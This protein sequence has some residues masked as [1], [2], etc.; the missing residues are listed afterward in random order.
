MKTPI[1]LIAI[2]FSARIFAQDQAATTIEAKLF[3]PAHIKSTLTAADKLTVYFNPL[4]DDSL[5]KKMPKKVVAKKTKDNMYEFQLPSTRFWQIGFSIGN[6][7]YQMMCVDNRRGD[8]NEVY[9][10][11]I[12]LENR[13]FVK[14]TKLP[15]CINTDDDN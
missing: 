3:L 7:S 5:S 2:L 11:D 6:Y 10:F 14:P 9:S 13:K 8:A 12:L 1:L 4:Y 15:P